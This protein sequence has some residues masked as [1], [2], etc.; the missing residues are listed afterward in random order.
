[1]TDESHVALDE[2]NTQP[3]CS[4]DGVIFISDSPYTKG[5]DKVFK[6]NHLVC[7][8]LNNSF[9]NRS[10]ESIYQSDHKLIWLH[11]SQERDLEFLKEHLQERDRYQFCVVFRNKDEPFIQELSGL[12]DSIISKKLFKKIDALNFDHFVSFIE[13]S[14]VVLTKAKSKF[15]RFLKWITSDKKK[16]SL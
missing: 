3:H 2:K 5:I 1:M 16:I 14:K 11:M 4:K 13:K 8:T 7:H 6:K 9:I 12:F 10:L 15:Q